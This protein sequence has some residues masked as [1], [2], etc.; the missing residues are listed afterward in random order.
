MSSFLSI[1]ILNLFLIRMLLAT[2]SESNCKDGFFICIDMDDCT[3]L[4]LTSDAIGTNQYYISP[5]YLNVEINTDECNDLKISPI[6]F[7]STILTTPILDPFA[8]QKKNTQFASCNGYVNSVGSTSFEIT[9]KRQVSSPIYFEYLLLSKSSPSVS[10]TKQHLMIINWDRRSNNTF[11]RN[12]ADTSG[13]YCVL[14]RNTTYSY[15]NITQFQFEGPINSEDNFQ[16]SLIQGKFNITLT[17]LMNINP[18]VYDINSKPT[19]SLFIRFFVDIFAKKVNY[20]SC[21]N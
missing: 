15:F 3:G 20:T 6:S 14:N 2:S 17:N 19:F 21:Y 5:D 16:I 8:F 11:A 1:I 18:S 10:L 13:K 9:N 7:N 12:I 4:A